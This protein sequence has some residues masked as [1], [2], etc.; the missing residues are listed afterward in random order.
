[1]PTRQVA[2][3]EIIE[4]VKKDTRREVEIDCFGVLNEILIQATKD[5]DMG[6]KQLVEKKDMNK[7]KQSVVEK[8]IRKCFYGYGISDE[9]AWREVDHIMKLISQTKQDTREEVVEEMRMEEKKINEKYWQHKPN[10]T[11]NEMESCNKEEGYNQ[12]VKENNAR[13]DKLLNTKDK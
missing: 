10:L 7:T 12:A 2:I 3:N 8:K 11:E 4:V 1:M 13:A 9:D 6:L 5:R